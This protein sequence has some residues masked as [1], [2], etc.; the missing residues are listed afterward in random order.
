MQVLLAGQQRVRTACGPHRTRHTICRSAS[1]SKSLMALAAS[2]TSQHAK[3]ELQQ[4]CAWIKQYAEAQPTVTGY[5][6]LLKRAQND[7]AFVCKLNECGQQPD[8]SAM[9]S[10]DPLSS[11][12]LRAEQLQGVQNNIRG[13]RA[14]LA[15][16]QQAPGVTS[17]G[18]R[19]YA[20]VAAG[21]RDNSLFPRMSG[22]GAIM[23]QHGCQC[24]CLLYLCVKSGDV[25]TKNSSRITVKAAVLANHFVPCGESVEV[26]VVAHQV[27]LCTITTFESPFLRC[28]PCCCICHFHGVQG[29]AWIEVKAYEPFDLASTQWLGNPGHYKG[30]SNVIRQNFLQ[31]TACC[32]SQW[33]DEP[34]T[35]LYCCLL[36]AS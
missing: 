34:T 11:D 32:F 14:E 7:L 29:R 2:H 16:A 24:S 1:T 23:P 28:H 20:E 13:M 35:R 33:V 15:V 10:T 27:I 31:H 22:P 12:R 26:D 3:S 4:L 30:T 19:F 36:C 8:T 9:T 25:T 18:T 5:E 17:L 21:M 6:K